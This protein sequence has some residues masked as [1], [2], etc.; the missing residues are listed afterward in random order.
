M[1]VVFILNEFSLH[2]HI[3]ISYLRARPEDLISIVKVPM[4]V[5]G[6]NRLET[7]KKILPHLTPRFVAEKAYE[8][9]LVSAITWMPK[10]LT[11]GE[12]FRRL[13]FIARRYKL[14][15][16]KTTS[17]LSSRTLRFIRAQKPDV[18]VTL[19]HQIIKGELLQIPRLGIINIHPGLLPEFRGIQPY[20]WALS[21]GAS[22]TG[23][24]LHLIE[25]EGIDTGKMIGR[26]WFPIASS[27]SVSLTY[28]LTARAAGQLLPAA[29][30][31]LEQG[32]LHPRAQEEQNSRYYRWPDTDGF[33]SLWAQGHGLVRARDILSIIRGAYDAFEPE[34]KEVFYKEI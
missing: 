14:P 11:R 1:N 34:G 2:N 15:F 23:V 31:A 17:L 25:D 28:Y 9:L 3:L 12:V 13:R 19:V 27:M 33:R 7:G 32:M 21:S 20:F 29:I 5:K 16:L 22:L 4:V 18:I 24:T 8:F 10:I 6:K 26:A 30:T